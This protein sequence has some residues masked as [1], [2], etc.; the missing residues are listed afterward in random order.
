MEKV[1]VS[2]K[3]SLFLNIMVFLIC[4][5]SGAN[6]WLYPWQAMVTIESSWQD[7]C[8]MRFNNSDSINPSTPE[9]LNGKSISP[10]QITLSWNAS[11]DNVAVA[12]YNV[13]RDGALVAKTKRRYEIKRFN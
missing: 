9:N 4:S 1:S 10:K 7:E 6:R 2:L 12:G 8:Q 5:M 11:E 3:R 13:Y